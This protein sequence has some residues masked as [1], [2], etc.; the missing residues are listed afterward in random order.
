MKKLGICLIITGILF[1]V[2]GIAIGTP[3]AQEAVKETG[4]APASPSQPAQPLRL[5]VF[6]GG[7]QTA[8]QP[9][10][11][12]K[13]LPPGSPQWI[14]A[15][16]MPGGRKMSEGSGRFVQEY[17]KPYNEVLAW[18]RQALKNYP[19]ARY[20]DWSH[21]MYIEDEG[22]SR[23]LAITLSKEGGPKTQVT[24]VKDNWTWI[25]ATLF[26]RFFGVF[27]VLLVLWLGLNI[28]T[29]IV[30]RLVKDEKEPAPASA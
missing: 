13:L 7:E 19:D 15:P 30:R 27:V 21:E 24:I 17:D 11:S 22:A 16:L 2:F 18:Y 9:F 6:E 10:D 1:F 26:L 5:N 8:G 20:R 3:R 23:W 29:F 4:A 28:A 14:G 12:E 25:F